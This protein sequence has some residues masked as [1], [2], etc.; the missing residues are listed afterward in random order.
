MNMI[1]ITRDTFQKNLLAELSQVSGKKGELEIHVDSLP[2]FLSTSIA[3]KIF[4][5]QLRN[6]PRN[7]VWKSENP[8]IKKLMNQAGILEH[9]KGEGLRNLAVPTPQKPT[10]PLTLEHTTQPKKTEKVY[11]FTSV[12]ETLEPEKEKSKEFSLQEVFDNQSKQKLP[13]SEDVSQKSLQD[14]DSWLDRIEATKSALNSIKS[15]AFQT[16]S[17]GVNSLSPQSKFSWKRP[18]GISFI[19]TFFLSMFVLASCV[20]FFPTNAYTL[21]VRPE[22]KTASINFTVPQSSFSKEE[23]LISTESKVASSG[24]SAIQ[25]ERAIGNVDIINK[26][27]KEIVL[28]GGFRIVNED[29]TYIHLRN[30]TLSDSLTIP[31]QNEKSPTNITVQSI[32]IGQEYG[33]PVGVTFEILDAFGLK[34]CTSCFAIST[35]PL[36]GQTSPE[37]KIVSQDDH[38]LLR[39]NVEGNLAQKRLEIMNQKKDNGDALINQNWYKNKQ[40]TYAFSSEPG[41]SASDV[42]LKAEVTTEIYSLPNQIIENLLRR[43][44]PAIDSVTKIELLESSGIFDDSN[45]DQQLKISY[46]YSLKV[47]LDRE[48][49][50]QTLEKNDD[51][52]SQSE[53]RKTNK[54]ISNIT[55][56]ETG[57]R[58]PGIKP[59]VNIKYITVTN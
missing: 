15:D 7:I 22:Q 35:T 50:K 47:E 37:K 26:S 34:T 51:A 28:S 27:S 16:V 39:S 30:S 4:D 23:V 55:R 20:I 43:E 8:E 18:K 41:Q 29:K 2:M 58:V 40:S 6:Y 59:A 9:S 12:L 52:N 42:Q 54:V 17:A 36:V 19:T 48:K 33:A 53:I 3:F 31:P 44:N 45:S 32:D 57:I 49:I 21:E 46:V 11:N 10:K 38:T 25:S 24:L 14:L 13:N 1:R 56:Y 5:Y